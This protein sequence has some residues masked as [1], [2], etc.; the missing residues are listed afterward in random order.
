MTSRQEGAVL[1]AAEAAELLKV[2]LSFL[3]KARV[4]GDGPRFIR[5][6]RSIRYTESALRDYM[7]ARTRASTS[8]I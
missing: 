3:A 7:A 5:V 1:T 8:E 6:G 2:S 4:S